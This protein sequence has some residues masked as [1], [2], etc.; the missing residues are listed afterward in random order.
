MQP[1][2][3]ISFWG[4][5]GGYYRARWCRYGVWLN[6]HTERNTHACNWMNKQTNSRIFP[7]CQINPAVGA[8]GQVNTQCQRNVT[9]CQHTNANTRTHTTES[10]EVPSALS[11][12]SSCSAR[13]PPHVPGRHGFIIHKLTGNGCLWLVY[14]WPYS[15]WHLRESEAGGIMYAVCFH[16]QARAVMHTFCA[17]CT[18]CVLQ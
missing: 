2:I 13:S 15:A 7:S 16:V 6:T 3:T 9:Q 5:V 4:G 10:V 18:C 12:L 11:L 1:D 8:G 14:M 17:A